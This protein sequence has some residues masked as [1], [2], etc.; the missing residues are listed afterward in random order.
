MTLAD[1][2]AGWGEAPPAPE[3]LA[4]A[5]LLAAALDRPERA[6]ALEQ[7]D[8]P[9]AALSR[10]LQTTALLRQA[11]PPTPGPSASTLPSQASI[12]VVPDPFPGEYRFRRLLGAGAFGE[13]WLADAVALNQPLAFKRVRASRHAALLRDEA[14]RLMSVRHPNLV[15]FYFYRPGEGDHYLALEYVAGGSLADRLRAEGPL[16]WRLAARYAADV[17]E[18]LLAVHRQQVVHRDVKPANI[19]WDPGRDEAVLTDFGIS[20]RLAEAVGQH[21]GTPAY[22]APEAFGGQAGPA[23]DVYALAATLFHL[24]TGEVPYPAE[25]LPE[26]IQRSAAGLPAP[27]PRLA[28]VPPPLE[29]LLRAGL[30]PDP[31]RRPALA[32]LVRDLR[33]QLNRLLADTFGPEPSRA[34]G[35]RLLVS[36]RAGA[37]WE[38]VPVRRTRRAGTVPAPGGRL[39]DLKAVPPEP[40]RVVL[41]TGD[42]VRVEV[43]VD[44]AGHVTVLNVGPAGNLNLL[45][46]T[47]TGRRVE[48]G[49]PVHIL[50]VELTP[51]AGDERLIALWSR[52]PLPLRPEELVSLATADAGPVSRPYRATRDMVRVQEAVGALDPQDWAAEV[53]ELDHQAAAP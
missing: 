33:A 6:D 48:P 40:D 14:A 24:L 15:R 10:S 52:G 18:G 9:L 22:M 5:E 53:L 41:R 25:S 4:L 21:A 13:V 3:E 47:D 19:L 27:E 38:P 35:V 50:D 49:R 16:P 36:K 29:R 7:T 11:A 17:G 45:Y 34:A 32:D 28:G 31:R 42:R 43:E 23:T 1:E 44:E 46:A 30:E 51:P 8:P 39:R 26:L 12:A 2:L 20:A 37:V